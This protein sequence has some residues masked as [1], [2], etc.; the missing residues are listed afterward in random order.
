MKRIYLIRH[1]KSSWKEMDLAD[2]DRPLNKRGKRDAPI[3]G[4]R[5]NS[6]YGKPDLIMTSPAKRAMR[7]AVI[8]AKELGY[9]VEK[10]FKNE[11][12]Y[13]AGVSELLGL[14]HLIDDSNDKVMLFGHNPDLTILANYLTRNHIDN[15]PT[16]GIFCMDFNIEFWK[17]VAQSQGQFV[18]FDYPKRYL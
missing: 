9:P 18:F 5:L 14:I 13:M 16:C 11:L 7:T 6:L 2:F 4:K 15:I 3:M 10:I 12:I 8:F 1:A 17:D